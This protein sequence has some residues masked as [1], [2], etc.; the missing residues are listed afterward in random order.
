MS[1]LANTGIIPESQPVLPDLNPDPES[2]LS[3]A[4]ETG[5]EETTPM[6]FQV[7]RAADGEDMIAYDFKT[8][9]GT[10]D[11]INDYEELVA[12]AWISSGETNN[13]VVNILD[14]PAA[15]ATEVF[16][17]EVFNIRYMSQ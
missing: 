1:M 2:L 12:S 6:T 16:T 11:R 17:F 13:H 3:L 15:E 8:V 7:V 10:A 14:D 9:E 5:A 4:N